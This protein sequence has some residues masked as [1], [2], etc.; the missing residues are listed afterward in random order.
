MNVLKKYV[1]FTLLIGFSLFSQNDP[2]TS[3]L[4]KSLNKKDESSV[5]KA[6]ADKSA[7]TMADGP[8]D[9]KKQE[10]SMKA[11]I[12]R[13]G[14]LGYII[15]KYDLTKKTFYE[16]NIDEEQKL[17]INQDLVLNFVVFNLLYIMATT[18]QDK[19]IDGITVLNEPII[20]QKLVYLG[21]LGLSG[22][23]GLGSHI[24][25]SLVNQPFVWLLNKIPI[26]GS[27]W[28]LKKLAQSVIK[29]IGFIT[30][31]ISSTIARYNIEKIIT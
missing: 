10:I 12:L 2:Q 22:L 23:C 26:K 11:T 6:M 8:A 27:W 31:G 24:V 7:D 9:N 16:L 29:T 28:P 21:T 14:L 13:D 15:K 25:I 5:A 3:V 4:D 20:N 19:I 17:T 18:E 1:I 30:T